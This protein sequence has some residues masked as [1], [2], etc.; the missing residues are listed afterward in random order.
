MAIPLL[1]RP[2][3]TR[4]LRLVWLLV[5]TLVGVL[6]TFAVGDVLYSTTLPELRPW[7][8][9]E[10]RHEFEA[11]QDD[12]TYDFDAYRAQEG[13]LF[14]EVQALRRAHFDPQLDGAISRFA[15]GGGPYAA[16][17][18][19]DWNRSFLMRAPGE[20]GVAL[21]VHGLSD[22]PYSMRATA[23]A[24]QQAGIS[25]YG[26][27]LPG[28]GTIP[29]GLD[30]ADWPDWLAAV[31][32]TIRQIRRDHPRVPFWY[33]GYSTGATL[34]LKHCADEVLAGRRD[35]LPARL[36][37]MSPALGVTPW[38]AL[39]NVQRLI[40]RWG[41]APKARWGEVGLELD[42]Y[43]YT[44]FARNAGAQISLLTRRLA[45]DL[46]RLDEDGRIGLM[47]PV[48]TFQSVA[49]ATVSTPHVVARL[50]A[51]VRGD[52]GEL[53]LFD[54]NR[55]SDVS[56]LIAF[57]PRA[58]IGALQRAPRREYRFIELTSRPGDATLLERDW[59]PG[60][61]TPIER[62]LPWTW[63]AD[64][65]SLSHVAMPF[66]PDDPLYGLST[67]THADGLPSLGALAI[68]GERGVL[69]IPPAEQLRLR[70]NPFFGYLM[71]R[72][73]GTIDAGAAG[74]R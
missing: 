43:K 74:R 54:V 14:E 22:S 64:V 63:P 47:P 9:T 31:R 57:S 23:L 18:D 17:L 55:G 59:P 52:A 71:T 26:V 53:V 62:V 24:L 41:V 8:T 45:R 20:R 3:P 36:F 10:T 15:P 13:R 73:I 51:R 12:G 5:G 25:V 37:L 38:A 44:S 11:S 70:S 58:V 6:F 4:V 40:S 42:P 29:A 66:P 60:A 46:E 49:D 34:G 65:M 1:R 16:R 48:T 32:V 28:H 30:H 61:G 7:H 2:L 33:V 72:M 35:A 19:G 56:P 68:R 27:R 21:L 67:P 39:A 50:Y 69:A